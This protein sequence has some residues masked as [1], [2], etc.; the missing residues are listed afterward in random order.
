MAS[1]FPVGT[2]S[3][4]YGYHCFLLHPWFVWIAYCKLYGFTLDPRIITACIVHDLGYVGKRNMDGP[5]GETHP[6]V[7]AKIMHWLFDGY[8]D[9]WNDVTCRSSRS[10][11]WHDFTLYHSRHYSKKAGQPYSRL[12]VADKLAFCLTPKWLFIAMMYAT[13]EIHEYLANARKGAG[14]VS[15]ENASIWYDTLKAYM[16][17]WVTVHKDG[18]PDT[19]TSARH[20]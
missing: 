6:T 4:L 8:I 18:A 13:G 14:K 5:E 2:R 20:T 3:V 11:R 19:W 1:L 17:G 10:T 12:C 16:L 7:G 15:G 9:T